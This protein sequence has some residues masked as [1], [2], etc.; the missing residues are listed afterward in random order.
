MKNFTQENKIERDYYNQDFSQI[1]EL[2]SRIR[3]SLT[4]K[5]P[6][7]TKDLNL[8]GIIDF[9]NKISFTYITLFQEGLKPIRWGACKTTFEETINRDITKIKENKNFQNF[10]IENENK[11]RIMLEFVTDE[12]PVKIEDIKGISFGPKRFEPGITGLKIILNGTSYFYMPTDAWVQSQ[13]TLKAALNTILRK[14]HIKD[15]TNKISQRINILKQ[16][17]Y[18]CSLIKSRAFI[19][20]KNDILPLYRGTILNKYS[21]EEIKN[22]A[23]NATEWNFDNMTEDGKFLYYYDAKEDN[24][25]DHEHPNA[26]ADDLYYNDLRH[27]GGIITYIRAYQLTKNQKYLDAAK[28]GIDYIITLTK[29]H[30]VNGEDAAYV[31][32]NKKGKLGGTGLILVAMMKYRCETYDKRY[33]EYIIKYTRH[34]L[35][36]IYKTGEML[37]YFIHPNIQN[38][39]ELIDLTDE[40]RRITF[41][42]YYPGEALLGLALFAKYF[43]KDEKLVKRVIELSK[44]ALDWLVDERPKI[45]ADLFT[46]LPADGWLM[47]AIEEWVSIP[48]FVKDNYIN[49]VFKDAQTLMDKMYKHDDSPYIDFE[50]GYYY[51]YGDHYYPDGARSEGLISAY[52]LAKKLN[53]TKLAQTILEACQKSALSQMSLYNSD[54]NTYAHL[55]PKKSERGIRFKATRQWIRVDSIQHVACFFFRLYFAEN[56]I[57]AL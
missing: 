16:S 13:M 24:S 45:Y 11:C 49:F 55:N 5:F 50:G 34:I 30:K 18:E 54:K 52:Y 47:Q 29:E 8:E 27:C 53:K 28:R 14:T 37:G 19:T 31:F 57:D 43:N 41:S 2:R 1:K 4:S 36:R 15:I 9:N 51:N 7:D 10:E 40:E 46:P 44:I 3:G 20:Y 56:N 26:P 6:V 39:N 22:Q 42:F 33:D 21:P 17:D 12:V 38:G 35:S 48:E 25:I 32:N 23:L